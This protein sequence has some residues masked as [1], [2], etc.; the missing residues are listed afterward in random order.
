M[1]TAEEQ[2]AIAKAACDMFRKSKGNPALAQQKFTGRDRPAP[3]GFCLS[4]SRLPPPSYLHTDARTH[5]LE[6][7]ANLETGQE[8][9]A[10][11]KYGNIEGEWMGPAGD[12]DAD[13]SEKGKYDLLIERRKSDVTIMYAH[14]GAY[15]FGG[16]ASARPSTIPLCSFTGG[17]CFAIKYRLAPQFPA[18]SMQLDVFMAY[19]SLLYPPPGAFH[20]PVPPEKLVLAGDSSGAGLVLA[21]LQI[22]L[23]LRRQQQTTKPVV[24]WYGQNVEVPVPACITAL[25]AASDHMLCLPSYQKNEQH[26]MMND[27]PPYR[28][29]IGKTDSIWPTEPP[30]GDISCELSAMISI[31][32]N[33][34]MAP[35]WQGSPPMWFAVGEERLA[36][37]TK[38]LAQRAAKDGVSV[39][40]EEYAIM[41]HIFPHMV[42]KL[43]QA[44][45]CMKGW[46]GFI[47]Q[48]CAG[49]GETKESS[50]I[51]VEAGR[52]EERALDITKLVDFT[53]DEA[54][55]MMKSKLRTLRVWEGPWEE[56]QQGS[57]L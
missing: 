49:A 21:L 4:K 31:V 45:R 34:G 57:K 38:L 54:R 20:A 2:K 5:L 24:R 36:D 13:L 25:S 18:L 27:A 33:P 42:P 50:A 10:L 1:S 52:L 43:P 51:R 6:A 30:R 41:P 47:T 16:P 11:P 32:Y 15:T 23:Q 7:V 35:S 46:A 3:K 40:F 8:S 53:I 29:S 17:L 37:G 44:K 12:V 14:G 19:L 28:S 48:R 56:P 39:H 26:D 22:I 9:F 55:V